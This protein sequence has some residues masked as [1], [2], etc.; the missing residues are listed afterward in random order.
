MVLCQVYKYVMILDSSLMCSNW[1][2]WPSQ[3]NLQSSG[4]P[5]SLRLLLQAFR[6]SLCRLCRD[7]SFAICLRCF[8]SN[9]QKSY[10]PLKVTPL[11]GYTLFCYLHIYI[12]I[13]TCITVSISAFVRRHLHTYLNTGTPNI[14]NTKHH[15]HTSFAFALEC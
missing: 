14:P 12:S 3:S 11:S 13:Y 6:P 9:I 8:I 5:I 2:I 1:T 10:T 7:P 4:N 15:Y